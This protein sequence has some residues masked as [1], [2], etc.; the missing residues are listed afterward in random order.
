MEPTS[1]KL[2]VVELNPSGVT[3]LSGSNAIPHY[4]N[5]PQFWLVAVGYSRWKHSWPWKLA[6]RFV[7]S[8]HQT[9]NHS[10][11][12]A[13]AFGASNA[14]AFVVV[15]VGTRFQRWQASNIDKCRKQIDQLDDG[16]DCLHFQ[17]RRSGI[18]YYKWNF[19]RYFVV[20]VPEGDRI[21]STP[22]RTTLYK[23]FASSSQWHFKCDKKF[24]EQRH[25]AVNKAV[26]IA[27][28]T[29]FDHSLCSPNDHPWSDVSTT[30]VFV[31]FT[32]SSIPPRRSST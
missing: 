5:F 25:K 6:E 2:F 15:G 11:V 12:Q 10:F 27:N 18:V 16:I 17:L 1:L 29:Y 20:A 7:F 21:I 4:L 19:Q 31:K 3:K 22:L 14:F 24:R 13:F 23:S 28:N 8:D 26:P 9:G 30:I 32:S